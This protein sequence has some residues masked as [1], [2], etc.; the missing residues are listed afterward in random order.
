MLKYKKK[1]SVVY[2]SMCGRVFMT[3]DVYGKGGRY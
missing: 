3:P 1:A 2:Y